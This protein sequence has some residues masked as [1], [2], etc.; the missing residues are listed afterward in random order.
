MIQTLYSFDFFCF[1]YINFTLNSL[2]FLRFSIS[3]FSLRLF[4]HR[5]LSVFCFSVCYSSLRIY[6]CIPLCIMYAIHL[7]SSLSSLQFR[8][9]SLMHLVLFT[10]LIY[11]GALKLREERGRLYKKLDRR[12]LLR[13]FVF[14][15]SSQPMT[16]DTCN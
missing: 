9:P 1:T 5:F 12:Y 3:V 16:Q 4:S 8:S 15:W 13:D 10:Q 11:F 2:C 14:T 7:F 6:T